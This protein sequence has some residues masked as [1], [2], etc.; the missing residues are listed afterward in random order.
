[1]AEQKKDPEVKNFDKED[2]D[3]SVEM[4]EG[5]GPGTDDFEGVKMDAEQERRAAARQETEDA[6]ARHE[7]EVA[8]AAETQEALTEAPAEE[9]QA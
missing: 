8:A 3:V 6:R 5:S 9:E 2:F 1:M 4:H 7:A